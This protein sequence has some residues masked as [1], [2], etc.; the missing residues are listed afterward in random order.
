MQTVEIFRPQLT[1]AQTAQLDAWCET[2]RTVWNDGRGLLLF[3][4]RMTHPYYDLVEEEDAKPKKVLKLAPKCPL[5]ASM[6]W[7]KEKGEDGSTLVKDADG[8]PIPVYFS[9]ILA[10]DRNGGVVD[11]LSGLPY[12]H[13]DAGEML[14]RVG[15]CCPFNASEEGFYRVAD[16]I[17][18]SLGYEPFGKYTL[19]YWFTQKH[20]KQLAQEGRYSPEFAQQFCAIPSWFVRGVCEDLS[21]CWTKFVKGQGG[22]PRFKREAVGN[23]SHG[24]ASKLEIAP[25]ENQIDGLIKLP[26]I[27]EVLVPKLWQIWQERPLL[28]LQLVKRADV[29]R[30]HLTGWEVQAADWLNVQREP[31]LRALQNNLRH[32]ELSPRLKMAMILEFPWHPWGLLRRAETVLTVPGDGYN[33]AVDDQGRNYQVVP[34]RHQ[35]GELDPNRVL[36]RLDARIKRLQK[37]VQVQRDRLEENRK[38][39]TGPIQSRRLERN[40]ERLRVVSAQRALVIENNLKKLAHFTSER[41]ASVTVHLKSAEQKRD[42]KPKPRRKAGEFPVVFEPNGAEKVAEANKTAATVAPGKFLLLLQQEADERCQSL[43]I[44]K[45]AAKPKAGRKGKKKL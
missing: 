25:A 9:Y 34:R 21:L 27:G 8:N 10:R 23:L 20:V 39:G 1:P 19:Q 31:V 12:T 16:H 32:A 44:V 28:V 30:L 15:A 45:P 22:E 13:P 2:L 3:Q 26:K 14:L 4:R 24:D 5:D 37:A 11:A 42:A 7:L 35:D 18:P 36:A 33:V 29:W 41:S 40:L 6:Y 38:L 43:E 17:E